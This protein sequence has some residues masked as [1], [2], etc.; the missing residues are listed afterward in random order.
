MISSLVRGD[1]AK[2]Q[3]FLARKM[4]KP[5]RKCRIWQI[6]PESNE[7]SKF[8][9]SFFFFF[10]QILMLSLFRQPTQPEQ[11]SPSPE[12]NSTDFFDKSSPGSSAFHPMPADQVRVRSKTESAR[13]VDSPRYDGI[14]IYK[15]LVGW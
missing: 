2:S 4:Q 9:Q 11:R 1:P 3:Q 7:F 10:F 12:T 6:F 14:Q 5:A 13:L 15:K 8:Q